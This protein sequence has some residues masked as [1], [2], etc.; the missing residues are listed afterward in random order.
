MKGNE[1]V[2]Q[3]AI[4]CGCRA[5]FGYP[6]TPQN[7]IPEYM[8]VHMPEAGGVFLQ[9]E[10]ELAASN[11]LLGAGATA[12]RAMTSSS[13]PGISLMQEAISY[14]VAQR[15]PCVIVDMDRGGPG[16]GNLAA[17]QGSY[18][19]TTRGGAH[20]DYFMPTL[21]PGNVQ[22]ACDLVQKAFDLAEA[23]RHPV[24]VLGDSLIGQMMEP[25]SIRKVEPKPYDTTW[26]LS[27]WDPEVKEK[28]SVITCRLDRPEELRAVV[29]TLL[30]TYK[31]MEKETMYEEIYLDDA[32]YIIVA[33][34]TTARI[35]ESSVE[36]LRAQGVKVGIFR[37]IT[38]FPFPSQRLAELARKENVKQF[39]VAEMNAGQ[40]VIDVERAVKNVKPVLSY[41]EYGTYMPYPDEIAQFVLDHKEAD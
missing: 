39:I 36:T 1:A 2:A 18:F 17:T 5:Y 19:Q 8:S 37:P 4:D 28:R 20:G 7:E 23:Y 12:T 27:G 9:A 32:E 21:A 34:G 14:M 16:L 30:D 33:F 38:L 15:L 10:S 35:A 22:E 24:I 26:A 13:G 6:I 25:V 31:D 40:M 11:M 3:A 41:A 29:K